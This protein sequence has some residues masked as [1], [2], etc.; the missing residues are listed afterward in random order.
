M[1][2]EGSALMIASLKLPSTQCV[3][4]MDHFECERIVEENLIPGL[5]ASRCDPRTAIASSASYLNVAT[6]GV[7]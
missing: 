5:P 7:A 1:I 4:Q 2:A 3:T 6:H